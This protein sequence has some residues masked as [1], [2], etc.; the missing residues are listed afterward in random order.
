[1]S[2]AFSVIC[3]SRLYV[4]V[5]CKK[6][7]QIC[8]NYF[9]EFSLTAMSLHMFVRF[10]HGFVEY[11]YE[12]LKQVIKG[13]LYKWP[14]GMH[15]L[16]INFLYFSWTYFSNSLTVQAKPYEVAKYIILCSKIKLLQPFGN[17][18]KW[19]SQLKI[20]WSKQSSDITNFLIEM[21]KKVWNEIRDFMWMWDKNHLIYVSQPI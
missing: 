5:Y 19:K 13:S 14:P 8:W 10:Q 2:R 1:M 15:W 11:K 12:K 4:T 21:R 20:T 6:N 7:G 18:T 3:F 16:F 17:L 9:Y